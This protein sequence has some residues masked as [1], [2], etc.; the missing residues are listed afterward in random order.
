MCER[1]EAVG[2]T[3]R[4]ILRPRVEPC[5]IELRHRAGAKI[6]GIADGA[7]DAR[8]L[9]RGRRRCELRHL[10]EHEGK[11]LQGGAGDAAEPRRIG[12]EA[13][14]ASC[15]RA[16]EETHRRADGEVNRLPSA[17][18]A[19]KTGEHVEIRRNR[20]AR[21]DVERERA[22]EG[23]ARRGA[24]R[25]RERRA[26]KLQAEAKRADCSARGDNDAGRELHLTRS[27]A[28]LQKRLQRIEESGDTRRCEHAGRVGERVR[29]LHPRGRLREQRNRHARASIQVAGDAAQQSH[30]I[31]HGFDERS[32]AVVELA[33][34]VEA[35]TNCIR[36]EHRRK[37]VDE[38]RR[39]SVRPDRNDFWL[40]LSEARPLDGGG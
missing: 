7:H 6:E 3:L 10:V 22:A 23:E 39:I 15:L 2:E 36:D 4:R 8:G 14:V 31:E 38:A 18:G 25:W 17:R 27:A 29:A 37:G 30:R 19:G 9:R 26:V 11:H 16:D 12:V 33:Q 13:D 40:R 34:I 5:G 1:V 35:E 24:G 20:A 28:D 21:A 32:R